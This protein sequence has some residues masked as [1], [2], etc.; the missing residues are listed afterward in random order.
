M[1][2]TSLCTVPCKGEIAG[3]ADNVNYSTPLATL[4]I[5]SEQV[6]D[7][8]MGH[9]SSLKELGLQIEKI[10]DA[11]RLQENFLQNICVQWKYYIPPRTADGSP[12]IEPNVVE[13]TDTLREEQKRHLV[14]SMKGNGNYVVR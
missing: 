12:K 5:I 14:R 6:I 2:F 7:Q 1:L 13:D 11:N 10:D 3:D 8:T 4:R 9:L